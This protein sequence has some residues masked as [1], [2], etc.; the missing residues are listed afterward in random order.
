MELWRVRNK[1]IKSR[2]SIIGSL[3][4]FENIINR[5]TKSTTKGFENCKAHQVLRW[6]C[7]QCNFIK[8]Q[9]QKNILH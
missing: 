2:K 8:R 1:A 3:V 5:Q 4:L 7:N 9:F 6:T